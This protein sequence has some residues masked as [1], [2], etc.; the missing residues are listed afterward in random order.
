[1]AIPDVRDLYERYLQIMG[2]PSGSPEPTRSEPR[3][4]SPQ[5]A[6]ERPSEAYQA[7]GGYRSMGGVLDGFSSPRQGF[8]G[9]C[10]R[11]P[12]QEG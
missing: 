6:Y 11:S 4:Q 8:H 9:G 12:L 1:M 2:G 7:D 3:T 5:R 10:R